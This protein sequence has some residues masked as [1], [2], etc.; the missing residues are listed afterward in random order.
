LQADATNE[1]RRRQIVRTQN[2]PLGDYTE[3]LVAKSLNL[4][5]AN[6]SKA[7]YDAIDSNGVKIQIKGR[8]ITSKNKS[9]QLN[10]IRNLQEKDFDELIAVIYDEHFNINEAVSIPHA[11]IAEHAT[12][13][14]HVNAHILIIKGPVLSD[15]SVKCI[16][17]A[18]GS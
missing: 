14:K 15:P 6:N 13:R 11:V 17:H 3:W 16:K 12:Y 2:N 4:D 18:L 9:T 8:R 10:A 1:L 5:L 7:G